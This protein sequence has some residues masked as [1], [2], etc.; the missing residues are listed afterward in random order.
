[1]SLFSWG[2]GK[3]IHRP[4]YGFKFRILKVN[5]FFGNLYLVEFGSGFLEA[6]PGDFKFT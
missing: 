5:L 3:V 6:L 4:L 1:M 2:N